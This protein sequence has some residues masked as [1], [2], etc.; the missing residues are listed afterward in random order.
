MPSGMLYDYPAMISPAINPAEFPILRQKVGSHSLIYFDSAA[1]TQKPQCVLDAIINYYTYNNSNVQRG[2]YRLSAEAER[3]VEQVREQVAS[4]LHA[5]SSSEIV[6][7]AGAT[8]AINM[9]MASWGRTVVGPGD[10]VVVSMLEHHS[11][12]LPW[13]ELCK[14]R[15][16]TFRVIP[17]NAHGDIDQVAYREMLSPKTKIV[18]LTHLSN[19]LGSLPP[20]EKMIAEAHRYGALTLVDAAQAVQ[21]LPIDIQKLACDF[22][23]LS[24]HK[25]YGPTGLGVLYG[26]Q[27]HFEKMVPYQFGG[28][29]AQYLGKQRH[30]SPAS[31]HRF[32]AGTLHLAGITGLG[33]AITF[34]EEVVGYQKI[35]AHD[36][37]L[38]TY[39][40]NALQKVPGLKIVGNPQKRLGI[41]SF[42]IDGVHP[43]DIGLQLDMKG[44]AVRTGHHC[45]THLM[46][47]LG[48]EGTVRLS[49]APFNSSQEIDYLATLLQTIATR[50]DGHKR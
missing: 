15:G 27:E 47:A 7:T 11:N 3:K 8:A 40:I 44:V 50:R 10:E 49:F 18:A 6:F 43:L 21:H 35:L 25:M 46:D 29:M 36:E 13:Q 9:V 17:I 42:A 19:A 32:E 14:E 23:V 48:F 24:S 37:Q 45:A 39:A 38:M 4:F 22:L 20:I 30:G 31:P 33:A 26:K 16:A 1:T 28:G 2:A 5:G 41:L 34:I 12:Y